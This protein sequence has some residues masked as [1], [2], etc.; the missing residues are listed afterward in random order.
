VVFVV[1][2]QFT[3]QERVRF[4]NSDLNFEAVPFSNQKMLT[5]MHPKCI[6]NLKKIS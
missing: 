3:F 4:R 2:L 1:N 5:Y 6:A